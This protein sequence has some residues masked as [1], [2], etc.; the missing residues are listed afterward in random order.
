MMTMIAN[1]GVDDDENI[2]DL[3]SSPCFLQCPS[4]VQPLGSVTWKKVNT[5]FDVG[6]V[7]TNDFWCYM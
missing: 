5:V 6:Q 1:D 4:C 7:T 3:E 2:Q